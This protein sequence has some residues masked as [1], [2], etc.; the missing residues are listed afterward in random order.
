LVDETGLPIEVAEQFLHSLRTLG[1][2]DNTVRSYARSLSWYWRWLATRQLNWDDVEFSN[3]ADFI[4]A[5]RHGLHPVQQAN[6]RER[7]PGSVKLVAS[8]LSEFYAFHRLEG[9]GPTNLR[10]TE[11][12]RFSTRTRYHFLAH[13]E[14]RAPVERSR[15]AGA[16]RITEHPP[17]VVNFE[18]DFDKLIAA[19]HSHR[20]R[21]LISAMYDL[22]FRIGQAL[23]LRHSDLTFSTSRVTAVRR[24]SNENGAVSKSRKDVTA[25]APSRF[26]T[27][28]SAYLLN[29]LMPRDIDSDYVFVNLRGTHVGRPARYQ[30]MYQQ[31]V[32]IGKR[33]GVDNLAPHRLRHTHGTAL[34]KAGWTSAEIAARL[35]QEHATTADKYIHLANTD[36]DRRLEETEHLVWRRPA[37]ESLK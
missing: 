29:E 27:F 36:V 1:K 8:A 25:K 15:L 34:A 21:L 26:F 11:R 10:L 30:N 3:L 24:E 12:T 9:R 32:A 33:A 20:D 23:G 31:V 17:H 35:G 18:E 2:A 28:Y 37:D 22:G 19:C 14:R 4:F 5:Y 16:A 13:V 7:A 6:G